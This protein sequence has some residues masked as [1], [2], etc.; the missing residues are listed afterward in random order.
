MT[1][2]KKFCPKCK[3]PDQEFGPNKRQPNGL[4]IW[5]K[6]CLRAYRKSRRQEKSIYNAQYRGTNSKSIK[7]RL[8][9]WR[10]A[11]KGHLNRHYEAYFQ[12]PKGRAAKL[13]AEIKRRSK[14]SGMPCTITS[15]SLIPALTAGVCQATGIPLDFRTI[16][17]PLTPSVDR[18]DPQR[19][20]EPD[21]IKIVVLIYNL[22]KRNWTHGAVVDFAV[23][24]AKNEQRRHAGPEHE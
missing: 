11:N 4:Q 21:N 5:C 17:G 3:G 24:L 14:A 1:T 13:I 2:V 15:A 16:A 19:G 23:S 8:R 22:A 10:V 6:D 20:Y 12:T 18:T 7:A 9:K